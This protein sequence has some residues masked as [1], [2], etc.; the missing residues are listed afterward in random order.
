MLMK[1][2]WYIPVSKFY[3]FILYAVIYNTISFLD[4]NIN[5][6]VLFYILHVSVDLL[7]AILKIWTRISV[8]E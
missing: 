8:I 3:F 1:L 2:Q 4:I 6:Y 7:H 5:N